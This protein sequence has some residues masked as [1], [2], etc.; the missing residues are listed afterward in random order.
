MQQCFVIVRVKLQCLAQLGLAYHEEATT[1]SITYSKKVLLGLL[2]SAAADKHAGHQEVRLRI[3]WIEADRTL[4]VFQCA[5]NVD[6]SADLWR[7]LSVACTE[8]ESE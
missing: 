5:R 4:Q 6:R 3:V 1:V 7:P 2:G 8:R